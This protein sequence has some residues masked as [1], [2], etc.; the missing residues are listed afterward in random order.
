[1]C[2]AKG[3]ADVRGRRAK[4]MRNAAPSDRP[5]LRG[6]GVHVDWIAYDR[7]IRE[8]NTKAPPIEAANQAFRQ[9]TR[10]P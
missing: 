5:S 10:W 8:L 4:F 6:V 1:L 7:K 3:V 2:G 9:R